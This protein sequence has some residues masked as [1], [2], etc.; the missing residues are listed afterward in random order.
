MRRQC[1]DVRSCGCPKPTGSIAILALTV[2]YAVACLAGGFSD[3]PESPVAFYQD[4]APILQQHCIGCHRP[5]DIAPMS[6]VT[7]DEVKAYVSAIRQKVIDRE[8]PPWHADPRF[9]KFANERRLSEQEIDKIVAWIDQGVRPGDPNQLQRAPGETSKAAEP[10]VVFQMPEPY[11]LE[12][13]LTDEYVYFRIPT[14]FKEDKWAQAVS[15]MPGNRR[16]VH[17]AVAFIE[18]PERFAEAQR[19]NPSLPGRPDVWTIL[20]TEMSPVELM[21]GT[22]RRVKPDAP[23]IDDGCGSPADD[24]E[25][26]FGSNEILSVYAPGRQSDAWPPGTARRIPAGSNII[27]QMH[28]SKPSGSA[29]RDRTRIAIVFARAPVENMVGTRGIHNETF[30]I[31]PGA[32]SHRV[33][34]C[35]TFQRDVRLISFMPH[36]HVRG[37]S[38][39]Y[40]AI[41]PDG[42]RETL[43]SVPRYSF[44]WQTLYEL[45]TPLAIPGGTKVMVTAIYD[46]SANNHHNPDPTKAVRNGSATIDEMM[47]GFVNYTVPRPLDRRIIKIQPALYD[48]YTGEY[49]LSTGTSVKVIRKQDR[50]F[51][52]TEGQLVELFPVSET[53]FIIKARDSQLTFV[54][55]ARGRAVELVITFSDK[56]LRFKRTG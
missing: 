41:Y 18:T 5:G 8:M 44:H 38:M 34:A 48:A 22:T 56:L 27:L 47:I 26:G 32:A 28:Y 7:F 23:V 20:D 19:R 14:N 52:E 53:S 1:F 42:R 11:S 3:R 15:F 39:T 49:E 4:I 29:E 54:K 30:L 6:L 55:D 46:N 40:E 12:A 50:L 2:L 31:P 17:H 35:W 16:V 33:T 21:D 24:A 10:D 13:N 43:L 51:V 45:K 25:S 37:K 36:M 9:G